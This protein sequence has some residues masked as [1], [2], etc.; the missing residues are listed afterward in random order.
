MLSE[1]PRVN[2][3][4]QIFD[5]IVRYKGYADFGFPNNEPRI[6]LRNFSIFERSAPLIT[7]KEFRTYFKKGWIE[8]VYE[9]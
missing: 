4:N 6:E 7:A 1:Y 8:V 2:Y 3:L 9:D 5:I